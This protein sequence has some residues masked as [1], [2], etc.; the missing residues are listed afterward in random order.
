MNYPHRK[1][2]KKNSTFTVPNEP[3]LGLTDDHVRSLDRVS[4]TQIYLLK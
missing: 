4:Y 3:I 2:E 1:H